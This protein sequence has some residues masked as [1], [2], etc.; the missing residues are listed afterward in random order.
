MASRQKNT[1]QKANDPLEPKPPEILQ[2]TR[3]VMLHWRDYKGSI[4]A[5]VVLLALGFV[6]KNDVWQFI[7]RHCGSDALNAT[8]IEFDQQTCALSIRFDNPG[9]RTAIINDVYFTIGPAD[10]AIVVPKVF[11]DNLAKMPPN[12]LPLHIPP[13]C[14]LERINWHPRLNVCLLKP[15]SLVLRGSDS[16]MTNLVPTSTSFRAICDQF[17][18]DSRLKLGVHFALHDAAGGNHDIDVDLG[19]YSASQNH[20]Y[21]ES[22]NRLPLTV[23]LLPSPA[24]KWKRSKEGIITLGPTKWET[25]FPDETMTPQ[26]ERWQRIKTREIGILVGLSY[27]PTNVGS[28]LPP[29]LPERH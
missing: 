9:K 13:W 16:I 28:V 21:L 29:A 1:Q 23:A 8:I 2:K 17:V 19:V 27:S 25:I 10:K 18:E 7:A 5:V 4:L 26:G 20:S 3:W 15:P 11:P 14:G 12:T 24:Q 6:F 22:E